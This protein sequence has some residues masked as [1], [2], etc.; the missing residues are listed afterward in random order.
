VGRGGDEDDDDERTAARRAEENALVARWRARAEAEAAEAREAAEVARAANV[1]DSR[2][3][4]HIWA[5]QDREYQKS[6]DADRRKA[7]AAA[8]EA[9][10]AEAAARE[11]AEAVA[12]V[13]AAATAARDQLLAY[14]LDAEEGLP[15]EPD[16][17]D[18]DSCELMVRLLSS[19]LRMMA[20]L[21]RYNCACA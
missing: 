7:E 17:A 11:Q 14:A 13:E 15:A 8:A 6:L 2:V 3:R 16:A 19:F 9:A 20:P 4:Q 5:E 10:A 18:A 1:A 12:A 21:F